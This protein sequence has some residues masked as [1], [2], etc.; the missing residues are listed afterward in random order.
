MTEDSPELDVWD[1]SNS[2]RLELGKR[3]KDV[4]AETGLSHETLNRWR[5]G[6]KVDP[7]NDRAFERAL[8]WAPGARA[9]AAAGR[10]PVPLVDGTDSEPAE[11]RAQQST[12]APDPRAEAFLTLLLDEPPHVQEAVA[13]GLQTGQEV[14]KQVN[15]RHAV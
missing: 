14:S 7:L 3:W 1:I 13:R 2:R 9:T 6:Y 12:A 11:P 5:K 8:L 10:E 4:L 15:G